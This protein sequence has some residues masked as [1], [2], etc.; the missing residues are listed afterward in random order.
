MFLVCPR[1]CVVLCAGVLIARFVFACVACVIYDCVL[2]DLGG[3]FMVR[4]CL[5][6]CLF[7]VCR[8][9]VVLCE[10][11]VCVGGVCGLLP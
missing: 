7:V 4:S 9:L 10:V 8:W 3:L 6:V 2:V 11:C 1:Y 5:F